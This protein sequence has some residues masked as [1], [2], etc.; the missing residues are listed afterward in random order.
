MDQYI[1]KNDIALYVGND[2]WTPLCQQVYIS[3]FNNCRD[4]ELVCHYQDVSY[5]LEGA[6]TKIFIK[7]D[8]LFANGSLLAKKGALNIVLLG[9]Y[10]NI[11]I[12]AC[13]GSWNYNGWS[14]L[15]ESALSEKY[16]P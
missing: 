12:V 9:Q 16:G 6:I 7:A 14:P 10:Y 8:Y 15:S 5:F 11:P 13:G 2:R 4:A 1:T 3:N